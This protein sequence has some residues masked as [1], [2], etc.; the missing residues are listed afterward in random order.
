[1]LS[2]T[3]AQIKSTPDP[4]VMPAALAWFLRLKEF[5]RAAVFPHPR[6]TY[7]T[8]IVNQA[9]IRGSLPTLWS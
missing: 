3:A 2:G 9:Q 1:M 8:M 7:M 5:E 4:A 6:A